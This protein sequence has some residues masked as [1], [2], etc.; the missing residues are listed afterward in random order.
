MIKD[1]I[2]CGTMNVVSYWDELKCTACGHDQKPKITNPPEPIK[3]SRAL[4]GHFVSKPRKS[5]GVQL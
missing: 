4:S 5:N 2:K 1:C 3:K